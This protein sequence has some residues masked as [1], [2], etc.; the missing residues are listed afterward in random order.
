M[1]KN[2]FT[3]SQI[4]AMTDILHTDS[5]DYQKTWLRVGKLNIDRSVTKSRQIGAT[6][7]FSREALLDA[8]TTGN[9]QIWLAHTVEHA[10]VALM[11][12]D[13]L[14]ARVGV[15]LASNGHSLQLD[16]GAVIRFVGE[17]SH[18]AAL[19]GNVYLDEF[20]WFDNP[21]RAA[22][23]A[24]SIACNKRH[25]ATMFTSPSDNID[26][27]RVW[28]G[29]FNKSAQHPFIS[30]GN[31]VFCK[32]NVWRQSVTLDDACEQGCTL[33]SREDIKREYSEAEYRMLFGCIWPVSNKAGEVKA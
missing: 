8:L 29:S 26:A 31:S 28:N 33:L 19:S 5:F 30:T 13:S 32:D 2:H 24:K 20:G 23:I 16:S 3:Q 7:L 27:F 11:R 9:D 10:R 21:V 18:F 17:E 22:K 25:S 14:S 12:M 15:R 4:Q 6:Q 1:K